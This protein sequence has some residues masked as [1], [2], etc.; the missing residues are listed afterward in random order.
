LRSVPLRPTSPGTDGQY[1]SRLEALA[2]RAR[3]KKARPLDQLPNYPVDYP[4]GGRRFGFPTRYWNH[5]IVI[6]ADDIRHCRPAPCTTHPPTE[7]S[8]K[9][10]LTF[11]P[12]AIAL[13]ACVATATATAVVRV[14][15]SSTTDRRLSDV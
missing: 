9:T 14:I 10:K 6:A 15:G 5:E 8:M 4:F 3:A 11:A 13:I 12:A 1:A 7:Q 2:K